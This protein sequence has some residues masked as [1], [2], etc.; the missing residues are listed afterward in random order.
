MAQVCAYTTT[1]KDFFVVISKNITPIRGGFKGQVKVYYPSGAA[2]YFTF[3]HKIR[4]KVDRELSAF[5]RRE[6]SF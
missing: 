4:T 2:K 3:V 1:D 5:I 6:V